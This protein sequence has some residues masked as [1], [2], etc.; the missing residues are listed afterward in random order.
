VDG[1]LRESLLEAGDTVL[2]PAVEADR[3]V[4]ALA[5][6]L[7]DSAVPGPTSAKI[8]TPRAYIASITSTN[9]T[10]AA[11]WAARPRRTSA[12]SGG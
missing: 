3:D 12:G 6:D 7:A 4:L 10:G 8:L 11:I 2:P 1:Q 9:C 5:E